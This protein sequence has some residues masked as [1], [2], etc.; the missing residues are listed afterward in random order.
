[1]ARKRLV[2]VQRFWEGF[3]KKKA[4]FFLGKKGENGGF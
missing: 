3:S 1:M 4:M 2:N